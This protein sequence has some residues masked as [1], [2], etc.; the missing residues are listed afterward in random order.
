[1]TKAAEEAEF[2]Y[3]LRNARGP[4]VLDPRALVTGTSAPWPGVA[5]DDWPSGHAA[6]VTPFVFCNDS[7]PTP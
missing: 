4:R 1:M 3:V 2:R 7:C 5:A 6:V